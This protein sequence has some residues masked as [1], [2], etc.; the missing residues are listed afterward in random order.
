MSFFNQYKT[1]SPKLYGFTWSSLKLYCEGACWNIK[2]YNSGTPDI[3][4]ALQLNCSNSL[5]MLSLKFPVGQTLH[6]AHCTCRRCSPQKNMVVLLYEGKG[7]TRRSNLIAH[8]SALF[9][10]D[11]RIIEKQGEKVI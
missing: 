7:G 9:F 6:L 2:L 11:H 5:R 3:N 10:P 1:T 4:L 8:A